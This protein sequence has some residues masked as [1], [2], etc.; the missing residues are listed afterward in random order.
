MP[1][2]NASEVEQILFVPLQ[3]F[4]KPDALLLQPVRLG[5]TFMQ[6]YFQIE[7]GDVE[8]IPV[9]GNRSYYIIFGMTGCDKFFKSEIDF[10]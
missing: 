2:I 5:V 7:V 4:L 9:I 6:I 3:S 8:Q 1:K 10:F